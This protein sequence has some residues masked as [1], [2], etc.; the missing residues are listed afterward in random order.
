MNI[1]NALE[2]IRELLE[3]NQ[4]RP[5][6]L[7]LIDTIE[8]TASQ[9]GAD[10]AQVR[11]LL[12]LVRRLMRTPVANSN[13]GVYDDLALLEEQLAT[14]AAEAAA[15]REAEESRPMPKPKKY[16]KQLREREARKRAA[17]DE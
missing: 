16:Y 15:R 17:E 5:E 11:S 13:I 3:A 12:E 7:R 10:R 14:A 8:K 9:P 4:A 1:L 6:T 2:R